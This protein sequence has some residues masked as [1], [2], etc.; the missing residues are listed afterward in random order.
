MVPAGTLRLQWVQ[1]DAFARLNAGRREQARHQSEISR[2]HRLKKRAEGIC[3]Y[4][5]CRVVVG[6]VV[7]YCELHRAKV[8]ASVMTWRRANNEP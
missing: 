7:Y 4:N 5:G 2:K 8:R 3:G 1:M 6:T